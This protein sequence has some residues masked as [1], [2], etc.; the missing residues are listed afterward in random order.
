MGL[1]D[2]S[3]GGIGMRPQFVLFLPQGNVRGDLLRG[4]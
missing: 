2:K 1:C 3:P 4:S